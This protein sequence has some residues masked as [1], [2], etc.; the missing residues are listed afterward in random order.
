MG[1][2]IGP[3]LCS[4]VGMGKERCAAHPAAASLA[5]PEPEVFACGLGCKIVLQQV[6]WKD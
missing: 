5:A 3:Y 6:G 2:G 1:S 4:F